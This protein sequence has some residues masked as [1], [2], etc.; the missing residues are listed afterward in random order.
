[1]TGNANIQNWL[2]CALNILH[3]GNVNQIIAEWL[4]CN[5][6]EITASN[7]DKTF[8]WILGAFSPSA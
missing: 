5:A 8:V 1:M 6:D 4:Q 7:V 2:K 3:I